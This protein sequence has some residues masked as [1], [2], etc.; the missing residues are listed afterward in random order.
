[1]V[2]AQRGVAD[3]A[4]MNHLL[5]CGAIFVAPDAMSANSKRGSYVNV[6]LLRLANS[7]TRGG[8]TSATPRWAA[9][10]NVCPGSGG[11]EDASG[12]EPGSGWGEAQH[13]PVPHRR[14]GDEV[15]V[16]G[17]Y[18]RTR[19]T[20]PEIVSQRFSSLPRTR[21]R[22]H[23]PSKNSKAYGQLFISCHTMVM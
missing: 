22:V 5:T 1:M 17:S 14:H 7:P 2:W 21:S 16:G 13:R 11:P 19:Q 9:H 12:E 3:V 8:A 20:S 18:L 23:P 4:H 15:R 6:G 10:W